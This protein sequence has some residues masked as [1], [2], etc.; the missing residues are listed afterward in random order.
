EID[1]D[2]E[3]VGPGADLEDRAVTLDGHRLEAVGGHNLAV[4]DIGRYPD[5]G[6][7]VR[8]HDDVEPE[9]RVVHLPAAGDLA[10]RRAVGPFGELEVTDHLRLDDDVPVGDRSR[11]LSDASEPGVEP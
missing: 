2:A 10:G 8:R 5:L 9:R 3:G 1:A 7:S 4:D 11:S 6:V